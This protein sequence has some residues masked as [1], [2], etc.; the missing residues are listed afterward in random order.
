MFVKNAESL[1]FFS[2]GFVLIYKIQLLFATIRC[3][4]FSSVIVFHQESVSKKPTRNS[5][6]CVSQSTLKGKNTIQSMHNSL[7]TG[8]GVA[9]L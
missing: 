8:V 9:L 4:T 6:M 2:L 7:L 3:V 1:L 5:K